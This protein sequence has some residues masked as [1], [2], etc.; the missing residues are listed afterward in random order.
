MASTVSRLCGAPEG[1][2][3][4]TSAFFEDCFWLRSRQCSDDVLNN[5]LRQRSKLGP[6]IWE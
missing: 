4:D 6:G 5:I 2:Y 3:D 1:L